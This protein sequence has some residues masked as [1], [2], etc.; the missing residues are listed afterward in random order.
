MQSKYGFTLMTIDEFESWVKKQ[1]VSRKITLIQEHH[2]WSPAYAQFKGSNHF[3]LQKN[4]KD[5]HVNSAGYVDIAQ[6][7]TT[8]PDGMIC[9]GRSMSTVPAG[10]RGA[11]QTGICIENLGNFDVGHDQMTD[12]QKNTIVRMT[13]ALLKKFGL[14]AD[15]G[16]TY[17]GWWTDG[18]Q[19]LGTYISSK[20]AKTCPGTNFFGGN[21]RASY[22]KN[23]KPLIVKAMNGS[24][25]TENTKKEDDEVVKDLVVFNTQNKKKVT[26]K[27]IA[28]EVTGGTENYIRLKDLSEFGVN[29]GYGNGMPSIDTM[30]I[31]EGHVTVNDDTYTL[32]TV[33]RMEG[34][35]FAAFRDIFQGIFGVPKDAI[36]WDPQTRTIAIKGKVKVEYEAE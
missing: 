25:T 33:F 8:Y 3:E 15:T 32:N 24:Y 17:H 18:G 14:S 5:Y 13:A 34:T 27:A 21:T 16:V 35:N 26:V 29:V 7:F 19:S 9:T 23:L 4:M 2:T 36:T 11:N 12:A 1:S 30:P 28:K 20:S 6:N 31:R 10:C 22:D